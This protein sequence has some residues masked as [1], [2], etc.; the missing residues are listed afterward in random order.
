MADDNIPIEKLVQR[1]AGRIE[2]LPGYDDIPQQSDD[3]KD[4]DL[5]LPSAHDD[6]VPLPG[7]GGGEKKEK[8]A[9]KEKSVKK[10]MAA[11]VVK[12]E[13][14]APGMDTAKVSDGPEKTDQKT[15]KPSAT[16]E[17]KT[18]AGA[19]FTTSRDKTEK[20]AEP[21]VSKEG[22]GG[23]RGGG[24]GGGAR[25]MR[26]RPAR[27]VSKVAVV[28]TPTRTTLTTESDRAMGKIRRPA[29]KPPARKKN[30]CCCVIA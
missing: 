6:D 13:M 12:E 11:S 16:S 4:V 21:I 29:S 5:D 14:T 20:S 8:S 22:G 1:H 26:E 30:S 15:A 19:K 24:R 3:F 23:G 10:T 2:K 27:V 28:Q 25:R 18:P 17:I 9:K 7:G